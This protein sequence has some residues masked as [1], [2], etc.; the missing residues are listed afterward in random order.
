MAENSTGRFV[1]GWFYHGVKLSKW[2]NT[3]QAGRVNVS[4]S[5]EKSYKDKATNEYKKSSTFFSDDLDA[6]LQV[7]LAAKRESIKEI[8]PKTAEKEYT[9]TL[10]DAV[11]GKE[12][13]DA[14]SGNV[15]PVYDPNFDENIPF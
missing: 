10:V 7:L 4:F 3:N 9:H 5:I 6:L 13:A 2:E 14:F 8:F 1:K 12:V 15:N 11:S